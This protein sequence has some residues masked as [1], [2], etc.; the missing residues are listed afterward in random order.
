[1]LVLLLLFYIF[2][3]RNG[4]IVK[5]HFPSFP[6]SSFMPRVTYVQYLTPC[7]VTTYSTDN[8]I[9]V[10]SSWLYY[11]APECTGSGVPETQRLHLAVDVGE[12][13]LHY[14]YYCIEIDICEIFLTNI[15][16]ANIMM[17]VRRRKKF[18]VVSVPDRLSSSKVI[19]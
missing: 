10:R 15:S 18:R 14:R 11:K 19:S 9:F 1:M 12:C 17:N 16:G 3:V 5:C 8:R 2:C 7:G 4:K 13:A 6:A